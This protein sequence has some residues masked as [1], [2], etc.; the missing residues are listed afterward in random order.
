[1]GKPMVMGRRTFQSIGK[2]L[3]GRE[4]IVVTRDAAF[5]LP[6]GVHRVASLEAGLALAQNHAH[7]MGADAVMVVGGGDIYAQALPLADR[8]ELTEIDAA[9]DGDTLFP[10]F[11]GAGFVEVAR[12]AHPAQDG[13]PAHAFVTWRRD[14]TASR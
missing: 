13:R 2:P 10:D 8:M 4:T 12:V 5:P 1:M 3:P 11:S 7:A 9:P 14:F 6:S